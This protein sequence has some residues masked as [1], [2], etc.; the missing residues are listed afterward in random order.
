MAIITLSRQGG[1][2]GITIA[3]LVT[4][5]LGYSLIDYRIV[6]EVAKQANVSSKW[7]KSFENERDS[8]LHKIIDMMISKNYM[9]RIIGEGKGYIN[10]D[11]YVDNLKKIIAKHAENDNCLIVGRGGQYILKNNPNAYHVLIVAE[12]KDRINFMVKRHNI[13]QS[14]AKI[15]VERHDNRRSSMF[16][17]FGKVDFNNPNLYHIVI[18]TSKVKVE[19]AAE[20]ICDLVS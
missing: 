6:Q 3:E 17:E 15:I 11:T 16:R 12:K 14:D 7:V 18:N 19:K 4:K 8:R 1:A 9:E 10:K 2:G 5:K 20:I 13:S